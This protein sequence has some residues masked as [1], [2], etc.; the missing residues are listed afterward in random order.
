MSFETLDLKFNYRSD[1]DQIH[2]DFYSKVIKGLSN[3]TGLS[4]ILRAAVSV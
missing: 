3:T 4:G 2:A 1:A